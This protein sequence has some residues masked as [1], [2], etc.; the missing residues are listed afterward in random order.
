MTGV[1]AR[2]RVR[3]AKSGS[4]KGK[5]RIR[6]S[7][8]RATI[9]LSLWSAPEPSPNFCQMLEG[10]R[11]SLYLAFASNGPEVDVGVSGV[12]YGAFEGLRYNFKCLRLHFLLGDTHYAIRLASFQLNMGLE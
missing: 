5:V 3:R 12:W 1:G 9:E 10:L 11:N 8:S 2:S 6:Q 7:Y 4:K